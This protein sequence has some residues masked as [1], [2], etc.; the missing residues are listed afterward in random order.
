MKI[1]AQKTIQDYKI[2]RD[3]IKV[4]PRTLAIF[5]YRVGLA[6]GDMHTQKHTGQKFGIG[7]V[8]VGQLEA[9]IEYELDLL[10]KRR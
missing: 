5:E 4:T 6:D 3:K 7:A 1:I 9:R 10:T 2:W 8:R